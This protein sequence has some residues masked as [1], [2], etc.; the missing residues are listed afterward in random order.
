[1]TGNSRKTASFTGVGNQ[2]DS[3]S[4]GIG[5]SGGMTLTLIV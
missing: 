3:R 2:G 1:M 5:V 4:L